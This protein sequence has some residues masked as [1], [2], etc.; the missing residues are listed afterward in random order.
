MALSFLKGSLLIT[1][2][3]LLSVSF[4]VKNYFSVVSVVSFSICHIQIQFYIFEGGFRVLKLIFLSSCVSYYR[5]KPVKYVRQRLLLKDVNYFF[6]RILWV[7]WV[8]WVSKVFDWVL[9]TP[10]IVT[11]VCYNMYH[12]QKVSLMVF[13]WLTS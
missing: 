5:Q 12:C 4:K 10:L 3:C 8:L 2:S 13:Q 7:L 9:N 1:N 6:K 11:I